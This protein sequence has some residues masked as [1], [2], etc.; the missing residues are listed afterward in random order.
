[1]DG[2][3]TPDDDPRLASRRLGDDPYRVAL[4]PAHRL[5]R[6]REVR[7]A[8]LRGERMC[9][10]RAV[11]GGLRYRAMVERLCEA[12]GFSPDF[13]Y[14]VDD[15]T[16][17]R[18]FVAAGLAVGIMPDMTIPHP[19]PDV[20]VKPLQG[21]DPSRAVHAVWIRERVTPGIA[22]LVEALAGAAARRLG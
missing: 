4:P 2:P 11:A 17:A 8:D 12:E 6:R 5:A 19:R 1:M 21:L 16:V 7:L 14:T 10:P 13:A 15:V 3:E 9:A 22:P 20:A 18:A